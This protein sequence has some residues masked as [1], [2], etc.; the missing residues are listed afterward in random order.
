MEIG[1]AGA[2]DLEPLCALLA[3]MDLPT[4][5]LREHLGTALVARE[6]GDVVGCV[7][8]EVYGDAALLR[9]LAVVPSRQGTGVGRRLAQE[10]LS[11]GRE[12]GVRTFCL[13]TT[14]A[15]EFFAR[16]FAFRRVPRDAVPMAVRQ[17]IEFVSACPS[18]AQAMLLR[19][20]PRETDAADKP[21]VLF[22]CTHNAARSQIAEALLRHLAA[23]RYCAYS[24]GVE[25][26]RVHP[27][28]LRVLQ[29]AGVDTGGLE[30]KHLDAVLGNG[31]VQTVI[32]VCA[33]AAESCPRLHPFAREVLQ[34]PFDDPSRVQ[35]SEAQRLAAFRRTRDEIEARLRDWLGLE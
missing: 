15:P 26:G 13:L 25:P 18:S 6:G 2:R 27:M 32:V 22:V 19:R 12:R 9:S 34:W 24:A 1:P 31:D 29:E 10:A 35:G 11:L 5:G 20:P 33:Q 16:H 23:D 8:L 7:A 21:A 3:A 17:S 14:T 28:T 30:S 4:E